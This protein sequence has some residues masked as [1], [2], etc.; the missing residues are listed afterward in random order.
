[1]PLR[2]IL[3]HDALARTGRQPSREVRMTVMANGSPSWPRS[4]AERCFSSGRR[5]HTLPPASYGPL[6]PVGLKVLPG[7]KVY[8]SHP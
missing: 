8:G 2:G 6:D 7:G 1:M 3:G 5:P 4:Y